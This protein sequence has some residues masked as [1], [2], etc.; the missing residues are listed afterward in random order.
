MDELKILL[1]EDDEFAAELIY[2]YFLD[3]GF[4]VV[5][6]SNAYESLE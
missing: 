3:Y 2:N 6:S 4:H 1:V 5:F